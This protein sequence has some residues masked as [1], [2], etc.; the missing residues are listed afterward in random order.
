MLIFILCAE[1][2]SNSRRAS[3]HKQKSKAHG[4]RKTAHNGMQRSSR[5]RNSL[6]HSK[7][8]RPSISSTTAASTL[9]ELDE[10]DF[11]TLQDEASG[12][13]LDFRTVPDCES[14]VVV[15]TESGKVRGRVVEVMLGKR[16]STFLGIPY[17]EPP[18]GQKRFKAPTPV[19][20]WEGTRD[21]FEYPFSCYQWADFS[22][23][24]Y[25]KGKFFVFYLIFYFVTKYVIRKCTVH[26]VERS[27]YTL[28]LQCFSFQTRC[29]KTQDFNLGTAR[30]PS[31][32]STVL[33]SQQFSNITITCHEK[34][35]K[36]R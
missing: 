26:T 5:R 21:A 10:K 32:D 6:R 15:P 1:A 28:A 30:N 22:F 8:H 36:S 18:V 19:K 14:C 3:G 12:H 23:E 25:K 34:L 11:T 13:T 4:D 35:K 27:L 29:W 2:R 16:V 31:Q 33:I 20:S 24:S 17:G 7:R 9:A